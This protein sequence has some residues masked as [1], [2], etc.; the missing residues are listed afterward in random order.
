MKS[1]NTEK[2]PYKPLHIQSQCTENEQNKRHTYKVTIWWK[3]MIHPH[4]HT[5]RE[6]MLNL[7]FTCMHNP[8]LTCMHIHIYWCQRVFSP[9]CHCVCG[10]L[11]REGVGATAMGALPAGRTCG[12]HTHAKRQ[13][14]G[15][16]SRWV[17]AGMYM[18]YVHHQMYVCWEPE[19]KSRAATFD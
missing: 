4:I 7:I 14:Y 16:T 10:W 8:I 17:D 13:S 2:L 5:S 6:Y 12:Q 3:V 9:R 19:P 11:G 18:H 1:F 15:P